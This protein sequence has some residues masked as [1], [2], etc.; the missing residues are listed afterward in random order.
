ML[1]KAEV[2]GLGAYGSFIAGA[3]A[4][5]FADEGALAYG[6]ALGGPGETAEGKFDLEELLDLLPN[7]DAF[8]VSR[9][10]PPSFF[11][12]PNG[13]VVVLCL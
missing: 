3:V 13:I 6:F 12:R 5:G 9:R 1:P 7:R 11:D 8:C 10:S 2:G 4:Y